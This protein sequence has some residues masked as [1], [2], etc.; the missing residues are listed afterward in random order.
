M[1]QF[2]IMSDLG[3]FSNLDSI[4]IS[5]AMISTYLEMYPDRKGM[6]SPD[7]RM[8]V[9]DTLPFISDIPYVPAPI[10]P[11]LPFLP[12]TSVADRISAMRA[13]KRRPLHV[14]VDTARE[15]SR[16]YSES[17]YNAAFMGDIFSKEK[18]AGLQESIEEVPGVMINP[19]TQESRIYSKEITR[20]AADSKLWL[21]LDTQENDMLVALAALQD[22]GISSRRSTGLGKFRLRGAR[23]GLSM[24]FTEPGLY[25]ALAPFIPESG[26]LDTI[27]FERSSYSVSL[28]SGL[29]RDGRSLGM[30]RY[31]ETGSVLYLRSKPAGKWLRPGRDRNRLL[32]FTGSFLRLGT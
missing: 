6:L 31:F 15:M 19:V 25:L 26:D 20:Y 28:F 18:F 21:H 3:G 27:D 16:R 14:S 4:K 1:D 7:F 5:G 12:G 13:R 17:G 9:T 29:D 8:H 23:F 24:G 11:D 2:L 22:S 30:Y 10:F 32:N